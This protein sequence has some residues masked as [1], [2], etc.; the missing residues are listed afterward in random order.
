MTFV[1]RLAMHWNRSTALV[2]AVLVT[3]ST[4]ASLVS[5]GQDAAASRGAT[6]TPLSDGRW[7]RLGGT[8]GRGTVDDTAAIVD[9][10]GAETLLPWRLT[11]ARGF[12][13]ATALPD[14]RVAVTGGYGRNGKLSTTTEIVDPATGATELGDGSGLARIGHT[15]TLLLD[16]SVLVIGG[17]DASGALADSGLWNPVTQAWDPWGLSGADRRS[18]HSAALAADGDV[19]VAAG[20][21]LQRYRIEAQ[22]ETELKLR[23]DVVDGAAPDAVGSTTLAETFP[24]NGTDGVALDTLIGV[25]FT[26]PIAL[27]KV[28]SGITLSNDGGTV[29]AQVFVAEGGRLAFVKPAGHLDPGTTYSL[30]VREIQDFTGRM[31]SS[32]AIAFTTAGDSPSSPA[33]DETTVVT[34]SWR[35]LPPLRAAPGQTALSGQTLKLNGTP[36]EGV[37]FAIDSHA[38]R[39]DRT[40]RFLLTDLTPGHHVLVIDGKSASTPGRVYGRYEAGVEVI[41]G[42]TEVLPYTVWMTRIDTAHAVRIPS[43]TTA[44]TVVTTPKLPGLE[45]R[46]P[47]GTTIRD[48]DGN[49]VTE[50]TITQIPVDRPPFALPFAKVPIYFTIQPGG[51]YIENAAWAPAR[52]IYPNLGGQPIGSAFNL[53][54]YDADGRGWYVYGQGKVVPP[55]RQIIPDPGVGIYEFTGAMFA[56]QTIQGNAGPP[57]PMEPGGEPVDLATGIFVHAHTDAELSD[58]LPIRFERVYRSNDTVMRPFGIGNTHSYEVTLASDD[59]T[60]YTYVNLQ[61]PDGGIIHYARISSGHSYNDAVFEHTATPTEYYKSRIAWHN[62]A[63]GGWDLTFKDGT[64]YTFADAMRLS[65]PALAAVT[66]MYDR[67]GNRITLVRDYSTGDLQKIVSTNGR[68]LSFT[69]DSGHRITA[70]ADNIGRTTTYAYD[71]SGRLTTVTYPDTATMQ[72]TY[73]TSSRMHTLQDRRGIVYLTN[74]YDTAGRVTQ[75][76]QADASTYQLAYTLNGS[77]QI[78]Q[79]DVTDPNG[80]VRRLS[81]NS[82]GYKTSETRAYG[83]SEAQTTSYTRDSTS[84]LITGATDALGRQTTTAYDSLGNITSVTRLAGTSNAVTTSFTYESTFNHLL[85]ITDPLSHVT[86]FTYD[87]AGNLIAVTDPLGRKTTFTNTPDGRIATMSDPLGNTTTFAY[88]GADLSSVTDAISN[89]Q[90]RMSDG[91]GR[92]LQLVD[93]SGRLTTFGYDTGNRPVQ[94]VDAIAGTTSFAF[95]NNSNVTSVTDALNHTITFTYD[96]MDHP[97]ARTDPLSS[98]DTYTFDGNGW[99]TSHTDRKSQVTGQSYDGLGRPGTT[100]YSDSSTTAYTFDAGSRATAIADSVSGTITRTYDNL[101][102]LTDE[103]TPQGEVSYTYD[104]VGHRASMTV[105]GQTAVTY[106]YNDAN[107]LTSITKG[108][109]V[110][111]FTYD[112]AG[113]RATLTYPNGV[114]ATYGYDAASH[115]TSITFAHS[116]TTIGDLSYTYDAAGNRVTVGGSLAATGLPSAVNSTTYDAANR[117]TAWGSASLTHDLNGNLTNDGT[118]SYTWNA[119]NQL[120]SMSGGVSASFAYD[121]IARRTTRVIA[122]TTTQ[123]VYDSVNAVQELDGALTPTANLITSLNVDGALVRTDSGGAVALLADALSSVIALAD[124]SGTLITHYT[125]EPFGLTSA[126]GATS[127]NRTEFTGR[128]D[129]GTG[130]YFYRARYYSPGFGRFIS[131]DPIGLNGGDNLFRYVND[132]SL[133]YI[134]PFGLDLIITLWSGAGGAGHVGGGVNTTNTSGLYPQ[135]RNPLLLDNVPVPGNIRNDQQQHPGQHPQT[136]TIP[137]TPQQD[138]A[139]QQFI[140]QMRQNP[141]AYNVYSRN[142]TFLVKHL[143][144]LA[145]QNPP[146]TMWPHD[147][148]ASLPR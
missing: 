116:G 104:A 139:M 45:L 85:T 111:S 15:T 110:V 6:V 4:P 50:I 62:A 58:V 57:P 54:N 30:S 26:A 126:T 102:R 77:G 5:I 33:D 7:L 49:V 71:T 60:N 101:D 145:G 47:A 135:W 73:D 79:T 119:R 13:A 64:V 51:A 29:T 24:P 93:A 70:M 1:S 140:D 82:S 91:A 44:E 42:R 90:R 81:F 148:F 66:G 137:T 46:I 99:L 134:D 35:S 65:T 80:F 92:L 76:T 34:D 114:V 132:N 55:G 56:Y 74:T 130:L 16:G 87:E 138:Q 2:A 69:Y 98:Q 37:T 14:G 105:S 95:D 22:S 122:S 28:A 107:D 40:G 67:C 128:D 123:Y 108:T 117:L 19:V 48:A 84:N 3:L 78:T 133:K 11:E 143:L 109:T 127:A 141:G 146:D 32:V 27:D 21:A 121:A 83:L 75:Q 72:Y 23:R 52:L 8:N 131:E 31:I 144:E 12:H 100:T 53:W 18:G 136:R 63:G 103:T 129:D 17:R 147:L 25:R 10:A 120:A 113:R 59:T 97:A 20:S 41:A 112:G 38:T 88:D 68:S 86:T 36:L 115:L 89:V 43:P 124:N 142:C 39:S 118:N 9:A 94:L 61:L 125:Y 106:A 96:S